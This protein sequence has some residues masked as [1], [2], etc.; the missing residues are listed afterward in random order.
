M[1]KPFNTSIDLKLNELLNAKIQALVADPSGGELVEARVWYNSVSKQLKYF[2]GTAVNTVAVGDDLTTAVTRA[3]AA[4]GAGILMVSGGADR[5]AASYNGGAG[6]VKTDSTG[7]ASAAIPGIDYMT[8]ISANTLSNKTF[9]ANGSGNSISNLEIADFAPSALA[10]DIQTGTASQ[11]AVATV[12]KAYVD[13]KVAALGQLVGQFDASSGL[14]PST[15]S[16]AGSAIVKGDYWRVSVAGDIV[17]LGHLEIGDALV[18]SE[19]IASTAA[20]FF[21]L[22]AN[23]TDA[24]SSSSVSSTDNALARFDGATGR[25]IQ[26]SGVSVDDSNNVNIPTGAEYRVNGVNIM[27]AV[28]KKYA[29]GFVVADWVGVSAPYTFTVA[30]ASHGLGSTQD[31][32]VDIKDSAGDVTMLDVNVAATGTVVL[33]SN[34]KFDGRVVIVG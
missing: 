30:A 21:V 20:D 8:D 28:A 33:S 13:S 10:S 19:D 12:I 15:G 27:T 1:A 16:G 25:I 9:D 24:V 11:V 23:L 7:A 5:T 14:L 2:D 29:Q 17:G 22:Q 31:L 6:I 26:N 32:V 3:I 18:A 34:I 4:S